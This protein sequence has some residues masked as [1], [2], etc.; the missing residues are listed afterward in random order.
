MHNATTYRAKH[1]LMML[2]LRSFLCIV[3]YIQIFKI[4][5]FLLA[6]DCENIEVPLFVKKYYSLKYSFIIGLHK[7]VNTL[8]HAL[9]LRRYKLHKLLG[10][11]AQRAPFS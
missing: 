5:N 10:V 7:Q 9:L 2:E 3:T 11:P 4:K 1:L 8:W 6:N